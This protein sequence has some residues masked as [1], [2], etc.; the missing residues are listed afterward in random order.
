MSKGNLNDLSNI[1]FEQIEKINNT[2]STGEELKAEIE[3]ANTIQSLADT[4]L[5]NTETTMKGIMLA[6]KM[7][8]INENNNE[9]PKMLGVSS[10]DC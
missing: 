2:E 6:Q 5:K 4:Y 8:V 9:L 10:N 3:K 1:L 7:G